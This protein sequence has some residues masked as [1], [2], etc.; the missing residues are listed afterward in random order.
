MSGTEYLPPRPPPPP[1]SP[2]AGRS[3]ARGTLDG[4]VRPSDQRAARPLPG[5]PARGPTGTIVADAEQGRPVIA[6][7]VT[8][9][10]VGETVFGASGASM[11]RATPRADDSGTVY[12]AYTDG[13]VTN[14]SRETVPI[15]DLEDIETV[16]LPYASSDVIDR[17]GEYDLLRE[18]GRGGMGV[19]YKAYSIRLCRWCAIKLMIAGNNASRALLVRFQNEAMLAARLTHPNIVPV[20]DAG[21]FDDQFYFVMGFVDGRP[22]DDL[23]DDEAGA[24]DVSALVRIVAKSARALSYAHRHGVVHR[25]IKPENIL[26][27][28]S[29]EPHITDFGIAAN[30]ETHRRMTHDGAVMGT[31]AYMSPEQIN[32]EIARIGPRSDVYSLGATLYHLLTGRE[33]FEGNSAM[34]I[35]DR[36]LDRE[37]T[38]PSRASSRTR[39]ANI[40]LDLD[41]VVLKCL[42]KRAR[43]RYESADALADD[44]EAWLEDRPVA[45]RPI[46]AAERLRKLM[47]RNR[48]ALAVVTLVFTMLMGLAVAFGVITSMNIAQTSATLREQDRQAAIEQAATL[49]RAIKVNMLQGRADVVRELV[50]KLRE[51]PLARGVEVVRTDRSL[52]YTDI[53]TRK[54]VARRLDDPQV[55]AWIAEHHPDMQDK[56]AEVRR[57]A[58][59]NIDANKQPPGQAFAYDRDAW[60]EIVG[61]GET[62]TRRE[63]LDDEPVLTVFAPIANDEDCQ[64]CH[65]E[66]DDAGYDDNSVR[67]V[68]VVRRSQA[69]L[70]RRIAENRRSTLIVGLATAGFLLA[71]LWAFASLFGVRLRRRTFA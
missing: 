6:P 48:A 52:A 49:E 45:A 51:D 31:P 20:Y 16:E 50:G 60:G 29:G 43:D 63:V 46:S 65:G 28:G 24:V 40:D 11:V 30:V 8:R 42:E 22:L 33:P 25:D 18:L 70:E 64:V 2:K 53:S 15:E 17:I 62:V 68:L 3:G 69:A 57:I 13:V 39:R 41:T 37:P 67:A 19:V 23:I 55:Q 5:V 14:I 7:L 21:E 38:P 9:S 71:A 54:R 66:P 26:V 10:P 4:G 56:V 35:M 44:L 61:A 32:G 47:R 59:G 1:P 27:D 34:E 58:F 12:R 36:A